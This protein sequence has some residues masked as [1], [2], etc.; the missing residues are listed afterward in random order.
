MTTIQSSMK[1]GLGALCAL[2]LATSGC[3]AEK[4]AKKAGDK[5]AQTAK[6]T[7]AAA[8]KAADK[9]GDAAGKAADK[10]GDAAAGAK[11]EVV[12]AVAKI[13]MKTLKLEAP[14]GWEGEYNEALESWTFEKYT[15]A[16]DGTNEPNRFYVDL[17]PDDAPTDVAAYADKLQKD[18]NFQDMG[19]LF[20]AV[21][22]KD[23]I[24]GGWLIV[25]TT[26]DMTDDEDKGEPS[27][28]MYRTGKNIICKGGT[29]VDPK[30]RDEAVAAC[31][32]I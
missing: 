20:T 17:R 31:K 5:T 24:D 9:V 29:F 28:V 1:L 21:D 14:E 25:G 19:Y 16:G 11:A 7:A 2:C 23:A 3:D 15:P 13:D 6:K 30:W 32:S 10:V 26:K 18:D 4:E 27:F 12:A 22:S 8:G